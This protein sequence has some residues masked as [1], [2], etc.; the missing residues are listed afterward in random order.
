V[1]QAEGAVHYGDYHC[2]FGHRQACLPAARRPMQLAR[3]YCGGSYN[4]RRWWRSSRLYRLVWSALRLAARRI[5][6]RVR[7]GSWGMRY[8]P[9]KSPLLLR[10]RPH[11]TL[12][13][14]SEGPLIPHSGGSSSWR[15]LSLVRRQRSFL[16]SSE[17]RRHA[18]AGIVGKAAWPARRL[19]V[20]LLEI[21]GGIVSL[22][23]ARSRFP[24]KSM[25]ARTL[26]NVRRCSEA[27]R[28]T[29]TGGG[30]SSGSRTTRL[31]S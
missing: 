17:N 27:T 1:Q 6:G 3:Q 31:P 8:A 13:A 7:S 12:G 11:I 28:W 16:Q 2:R 5:I 26:L 14:G 19:S 21:A 20:G 23:L 29:G 30:S 10:G 22:K 25:K 4:G 9:T 24:A 15:W 18:D